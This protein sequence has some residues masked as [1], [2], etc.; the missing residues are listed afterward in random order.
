V[1]GGAAG[2]GSSLASQTLT[3]NYSLSQTINETS[4]GMATGWLFHGLGA[5]AARPGNSVSTAGA[6]LS[7]DISAATPV[8]RTGLAGELNV[9]TPN[10]SA[11]IGNQTYTGH[12]LDQMQSRGLTP[13]VVDDAIGFGVAT[14]S[15]NGTTIYYSAANNVSVVTSASGRIV[16]VGFGQFKPR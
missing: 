1:A 12:A 11:I 16:T 6:S 8:G 9:T 15:A 4:F 13:A 10:S 3:G 5:L 14:Q 2:F 7:G